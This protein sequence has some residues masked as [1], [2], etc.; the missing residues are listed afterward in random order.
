MSDSEIQ[1]LERRIATGDLEA[2]P[3]LDA[4]TRRAGLPLRRVWIVTLSVGEYSDHWERPLDPVHGT[5]EGALFHMR[6]FAASEQGRDY[7]LQPDPDDPEEYRGR[8]HARLSIYWMPL[9]D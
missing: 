6:E 8:E 4:A 9:A 7:G 2:W 5:K 1:A 3:L